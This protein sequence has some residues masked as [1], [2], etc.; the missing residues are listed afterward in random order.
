MAQTR[1]MEYENTKLRDGELIEDFA[2]RFS[3]V[4]QRLGDPGDAE[5]D[6]KAVKK[7]HVSFGLGTS[8][9]FFPW[10]L[11]LASPSCRLTRS[12]AP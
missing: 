9:S 1:H 6:E 11:S 2:L 3:G 10:K 4:L 5:P 8:T 12:P 7:Y